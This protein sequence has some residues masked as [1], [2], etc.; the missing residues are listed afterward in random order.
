MKFRLNQQQLNSFKRAIARNPQVIMRAV[1]E[2]LARGISV[3]NRGI[4][5][6]PWVMGASG[7]GSPVDTAN[8]RDTHQKQVRPFEA[9]IFP[10]AP[11]AGY[12]HGDDGKTRNVRG[13][14]LRPWLDFIEKNSEDEINQLSIE[15]LETVTNDLAK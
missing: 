9:T 6:N 2:F 1:G 10:T 3:Y 11:Y 15:L 8:L 12:V 5:R 14:Q 4:I 7:G 13:V